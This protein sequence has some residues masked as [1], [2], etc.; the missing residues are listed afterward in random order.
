MPPQHFWGIPRTI[1]RTAIVTLVLVLLR[2]LSDTFSARCVF[3]QIQN[4]YKDLLFQLIRGY[5]EMH[6]GRFVERN[7][8]ELLNHMVQTA[9]EVADFY[10]C[11]LELV[12]SV[13]VVVMMTAAILYKSAIAACGL[14]V[15][16]LVFY[17]IH[18]FLIRKQLRLAASSRER[19]S[20]ELRRNLADMLSSG[21]EIRAYGNQAFFYDRARKHAEDVTSGNLRVLFLPQI[22]RILADQGVILLFLGV[23]I[24][25][26]MQHGN[27]RQLIS[28]LVFY[29][30]LSRRLLPLISQISFMIGKVESSYEV[31]K[32]FDAELDECLR[33]RSPALP[34][35]PP[36]QGEVLELDRINF[37]FQDGISILRDVT[38]HLRMGEVVVLQGASGCGKSTLLN[39]LAGLWQPDTGVVRIDRS[40]VAYVPQEVPLLDDTIRNNLLFGSAEKSDAEIIKALTVV[41]LNEF[42]AALPL[43]L[44][45]SI[46]DNGVL[47]SGGERQR[48]GLA[49]AILREASLLLLD[50][51]TAALDEENERQ[52]FE[53]ISRS[54]AAVLLVTHRTHVQSFA[55]RVF[56]LRG[57]S[58]DEVHFGRVMDEDSTPASITPANIYRNPIEAKIVIGARG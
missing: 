52:I 41:R 21:K 10:H 23:V 48:L 6:W 55:H 35:L 42:V 2:A 3:R 43:G 34:L 39:L 53:N 37:S 31:V 49:R 50:E 4:L 44:Q 26:Q 38:L 40:S 9:S 13:I 54:G 47:F 7:R 25:V 11:C 56:Q 14:G 58:L 16:V 33:Y 36:R 57:G 28:L 46:G 20:R 5:S 17:S 8:S 24:V 22:A 12:A 1:L 45:T 29:F 27:S 32:V 51:A 18:R 19:S 30:A 15:A